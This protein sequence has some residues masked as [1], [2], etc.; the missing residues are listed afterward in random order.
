MPTSTT[1][2]LKRLFKS[3]RTLALT[4]KI[5]KMTGKRS[6]DSSKLVLRRIMGKMKAPEYLTMTVKTRSMRAP[7]KGVA[8]I[9][10]PTKFLHSSEI[11]VK[12][13]L[14]RLFSQQN[15]VIKTDAFSEGRLHLRTSK[16]GI[17]SSI[18]IS[19]QE[20]TTLTALSSP[21]APWYDR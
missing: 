15:L 5:T 18:T 12:A 11:K 14:T 10:T 9:L 13:K 3:M 21:L 8:R 17:L 20:V 19:R 7:L 1:H 2:H 6:K 16:V 4:T